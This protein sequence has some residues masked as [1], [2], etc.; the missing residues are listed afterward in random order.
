MLLKNPGSTL[1]AVATLSLGIGANTAIFSVANA[2]LLR[3]LPCLYLDRWL[4]SGAE[5]RVLKIS[6]D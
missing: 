4:K 6:R 1:I 2:I 3:P 5:E